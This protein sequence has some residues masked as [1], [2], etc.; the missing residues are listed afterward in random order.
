MLTLQGLLNSQTDLLCSAK[1]KLARHKESSAEYREMIKHRDGLLEYQREQGH[2]VFHNCNYVIS[3][4]G[5]DRRR[6]ILF[7]IFKVGNFEMRNGQYY[8]DLQEVD[9]LS[10]LNNRVVINWGNNAIAWHQWYHT[11]IKEVLE[12]LPPGYI[13]SFPG[14]LNFTLDFA[15]LQKLVHNPEANADWKHHLSAVNGIYMILDTSTGKQYIGSAYGQAGIWQRW[16]NY[17]DCI[18]G[19][20]KELIALYESDST[21]HRH[22]LYSVLQPLPSNITQ[23]EITQ[24]ESLY[25]R[26]FGSRAHGLN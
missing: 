11:Q 14:L 16:S 18:H 2:P 9:E 6:S 1:V 23:R 8:Y 7:G 21:C 10:Y 19:G 4:V 26:K 22:F 17:A 15:E 24:L 13:G 12:I 3:F 20:N 5:G 25:K